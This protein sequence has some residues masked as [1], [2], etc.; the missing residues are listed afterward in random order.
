M[1]C[2]HKINEIITIQILTSAMQ[3]HSKQPEKQIKIL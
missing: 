3:L 1:R 2:Y